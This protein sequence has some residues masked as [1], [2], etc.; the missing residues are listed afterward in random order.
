MIGPYVTLANDLETYGVKLPKTVTDARAT[1]EA[2]NAAA[3]VQPVADLAADYAAGKITAANVADRLHD[4]ASR[5]AAVDNM[6]AALT[7]VD[8]GCQLTTRRGI[9]DS[10]EKIA[11]PCGPSTTPPRWCRPPGS[12]SG[13]TRPPSR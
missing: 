10:A 8:S 11:P 12:T 9:R 2:A 7:A 6:R 1:I 4:T 13:A 5:I 3:A